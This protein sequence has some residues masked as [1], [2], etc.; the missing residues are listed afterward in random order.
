[1]KNG[2]KKSFGI[3]TFCL[4]W[5][6]L[7]LSGCGNQESGKMSAPQG[8][9]LNIVTTIFPPYDF[10]R[11]LGGGNVNVT[12]LLSPGMESHFYEPTPQDMIAINES[13]LFI[14]V[15]GES[16][17]WVGDMMDSLEHGNLRT[18]TL[19]D[20]VETVEEESVEGME[21]E[22][23][24]EEHGEA[25]DEHV[26]TSP[27]NAILILEKIADALC[28]ADPGHE[29]F[30][31][32]NQKVYQA[33][34]ESLDGEYL[35]VVNAG[36]RKELIFGDRFPFRYLS[37]AYGLDYYAAFPGCSPETEPS[38]ATIAFL[39]DK[40]VAD[41]IPLVLYLEL[42]NG[43]IADAIAEAAGVGTAMLHSC[44]NVSADEVKEGATYMGLM[45][46][47]LEVLK[48]ALG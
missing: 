43:K 45:E 36:S 7:L 38:A 31:R 6:I 35:E 34:L 37:D 46:Q 30:Y 16:D 40:V 11:I 8:D 44:H 29:A 18:L 22:H 5:G 48:E 12:M 13:D 15:G 20:C 14:Y 42:S 1:M 23:G 4:L 2:N 25:Y 21:V 24:E 39:T 3:F 10:A 32:Q 17:A 27:R 19:M 9:K 28:E 41:G 33:G 47:N 26:W